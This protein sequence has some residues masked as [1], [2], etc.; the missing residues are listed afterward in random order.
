MA[1][2]ER[3]ELVRGKI[4]TGR[5]R[6][7]AKES[8]ICKKSSFPKLLKKRC[9]IAKGKRIYKKRL[10]LKNLSISRG[11]NKGGVGRRGKKREICCRSLGTLTNRH[12]SRPGVIMKKK[13][14][15]RK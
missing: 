5:A 10:K 4:N 7:A 15:Q 13:S 11:E 6:P 1:A 12:S 14:H 2:Q 9:R 3:G 8:K